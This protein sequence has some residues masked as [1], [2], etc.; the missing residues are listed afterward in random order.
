MPGKGP[1]MVL[2]VAMVA[3]G[4]GVLGHPGWAAT[5]G[6]PDPASLAEA[7][8]RHGQALAPLH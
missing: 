4:W 3:L 7:M 6:P 1:A 2:T 8:R 5:G